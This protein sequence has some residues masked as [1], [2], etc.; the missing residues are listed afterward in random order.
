LR[1]LAARSIYDVRSKLINL[2]N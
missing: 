2:T 1:Q